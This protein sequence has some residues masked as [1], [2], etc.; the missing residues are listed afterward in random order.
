MIKLNIDFDINNATEE[1]IK[2]VVNQALY[3][4]LGLYGGSFRNKI[5]K[6]QEEYFNKES[7]FAL[8]KP[9]V[10]DATSTFIGDLP[11][12][13]TKSES[14]AEK[15]RISNFTQKLY[16]N[17]FDKHIKKVA[18][19]SSMTGSGYLLLYHDLGDTF[20]KFRFLN[21]LFTNVVYSCGVDEKPLFAFN[22]VEIASVN[23]NNNGSIKYRV[24]VYTKK[25]VLCF[26]TKS[27]LAWNTYRHFAVSPF[28]C[29]LLTTFNTILGQQEDTFVYR[30][31]HDYKDI[32][33][34]EFPNNYERVNDTE[35][36][37]EL[38]KLYNKL[39]EQRTGN[40]EDVMRYILLLKNVRIGDKKDQEDMKTMLESSR[41]LP[42]EG[43]NADA[44]LLTN[45]L[46]QNDL[47]TL[48]KS[49][50]DN[51]HYISRIPDLSSVDFSQNASDPII[52]I[53]TKPLLDLCLE[54]ESWFTE[55]Y[56][57]ALDLALDFGNQYGGNEVKDYNFDISKITLKYSHTL[58][59]NDI[60]ATNMAVNLIN[61][62]VGSPRE[63]LQNIKAIGN[64]D[65][66][67]AELEK[68][69]EFVDKRKIMLNNINKN[70]GVNDYN[71]QK[72]NEK[73]KSRNQNDN[74]V[75]ATKGNAN[76]IS[77]EKVV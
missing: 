62:G 15:K 64:V 30:V 27:G 55:P 51:I 31:P 2:G 65:D 75:N 60:D 21:P 67:M 4:Q 16:L 58:P 37:S 56:I 52:K 33:I 63:L 25:E 11:D 73:L 13:T 41:I 77:D 3:I 35:C 14:K 42:I 59:S 1:E 53:K 69:L 34:I 68:W 72:Q 6:A 5:I 19:D 71:I 18:K 9:M 22:V 26:E 74:I 57:K 17:G 46:N 12:I 61:A 20:T 76:D 32:P 70:D 38:I 44:K 54:K 48:A 47:E 24:Y 28:K 43:D 29:F 8:K 39:Q 50:K 23:K 45:V 40:V 10:D 7:K 49:I 66:Y 36:V